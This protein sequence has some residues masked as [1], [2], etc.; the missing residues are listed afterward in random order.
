M[1][2]QNRV[3]V[4]PG[5]C[6]LWA[7]LLLVLPLELLAAAAVA[8]V[9]H[10]LCH[11]LMI[12]LTGEKILGITVGAGGMVMETTPM[13]PGKELLCALAGPM[14]SFLLGALVPGLLLFAWVQGGFNLLPLYPL[15]GGRALGCLLQMIFPNCWEQVLTGVEITTLALLLATALWLRVGFWPVAVWAVCAMRKIPCKEG[16]FGVQ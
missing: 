1:G 8:A 16:R 13:S 6:I 15:D 14:G 3:E 7:F 2:W 4:T 11:G 12:W 5:F 10:E 9:F